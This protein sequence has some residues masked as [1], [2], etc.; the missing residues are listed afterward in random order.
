MDETCA[1][2]FIYRLFHR[3]LSHEICLLY[4]KSQFLYE[5][6]LWNSKWSKNISS[7]KVQPKTIYNTVY[8]I[9]QSFSLYLSNMFLLRLEV[10]LIF[11]TLFFLTKARGFFNFLQ[12]FSFVS[13]RNVRPFLIKHFLL[14]QFNIMLILERFSRNVFVTQ[15]C[16]IPLS[17]MSRTLHSSLAI[18]FRVSLAWSAFSWSSRF[19]TNVVKI[20]AA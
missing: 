14:S 19:L 18:Y 16:S 20:A 13:F 9:L 17:I 11:S 10:L 5:T 12:T 4:L 8:Y 1:Q 7:E 3:T 6:F 2:I 15:D